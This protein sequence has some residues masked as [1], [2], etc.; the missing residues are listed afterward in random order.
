[1]ILREEAPHPAIVANLHTLTLF[2]PFLAA[3]CLLGLVGRV[4]HHLRLELVVVLA[5]LIQSLLH[6]P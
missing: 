6:V 2:R 4:R 3:S 1:M 5:D